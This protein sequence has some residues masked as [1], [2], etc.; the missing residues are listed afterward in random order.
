MTLRKGT[1]LTQEPESA[2]RAGGDGEQVRLDR[3]LGG[4]REALELERDGARARADALWVATAGGR[5]VNSIHS[6]PGACACLVGGEGLG[7]AS[8]LGVVIAP[9]L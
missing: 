2:A 9:K 8:T 5:C 1:R 6:R 3:F 7:S 4:A